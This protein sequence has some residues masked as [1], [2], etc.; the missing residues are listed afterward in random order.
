VD[1]L[2]KNLYIRGA[3][4]LRWMRMAETGHFGWIP[5]IRNLKV[6]IRKYMFEG[7]RRRMNS[8]IM[9]QDQET[10]IQS[11]KYVIK[12]LN[13]LLEQAG[14]LIIF[15]F[16]GHLMGGTKDNHKY[17]KMYHVLDKYLIR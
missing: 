8:G 9:I 10:E 6:E 2:V 16:P 15:K 4:P 13:G 14:N 5:E 7:E 11:V 1:F 3:A 17:R 12:E